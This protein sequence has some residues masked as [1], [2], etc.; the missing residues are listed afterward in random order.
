MNSPNAVQI[1]RAWRQK[2]SAQLSVK[3]ERRPECEPQLLWSSQSTIRRI[4][5][6]PTTIVSAHDG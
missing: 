2:Q 3:Q 5:E 6:L 1:R 4:R